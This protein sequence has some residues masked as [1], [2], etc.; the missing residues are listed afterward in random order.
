MNSV[1]TRALVNEEISR[2]DA[3]SDFGSITVS[4]ALFRIKVYMLVW[5]KLLLQDDIGGLEI[6]NPE[7]REFFV[8]FF[9]CLWMPFSFF[10]KHFFLA[11]LSC[12]W[13]RAP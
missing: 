4:H 5:Y 10:K 6:Q 13:F 1:S 9:S 2:I 3:H 7:S 11:S 12:T 8:S